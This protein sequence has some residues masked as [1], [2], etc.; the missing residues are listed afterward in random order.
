MSTI[1]QVVK[2]P[3]K[4]QRKNTMTLFLG[5]NP[6]K[7]GVCVRVY[8]TKPKK[9]HSGI[10]KVAKVYMPSRKRHVLASIPGQ[11]HNLN[12]HS[13]VLVRGGRV[14][15]IPGMHARLLRNKYD[16]GEKENLKIPRRRRRSKYGV[17]LERNR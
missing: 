11:G 16:F 13:V 15:D 2:N 6:Q 14:R 10:R 12:T 5:K 4:K 3:R 9:P 1:N 8:T 7:K 17:P